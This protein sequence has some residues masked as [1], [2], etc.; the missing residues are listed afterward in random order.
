MKSNDRDRSND[1]TIGRVIMDLGVS[2]NEFFPCNKPESKH[3]SIVI[4]IFW[5]DENEYFQRI[6]RIL[7]EAKEKQVDILIFPACAFIWTHTHHLR[8]YMRAMK[9]MP[10]VVAGILRLPRHK[11]Q[12]RYI[13]SAKVWSR[14][15]KVFEIEYGTL[16]WIQLG[17]VSSMVAIAPGLK[18][19]CTGPSD[20][21]HTSMPRPIGQVLRKYSPL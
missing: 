2:R 20:I 3:K 7:K 6:E 1:L 18:Q 17:K 5:R 8:R 13:E 15:R 19:L 10:W 21:A 12:V 14:G 11:K 9:K 4:K 16:I